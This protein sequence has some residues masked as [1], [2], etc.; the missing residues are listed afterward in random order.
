MSRGTE[1]GFCCFEP[2]PLAFKQKWT[3]LASSTTSKHATNTASLVEFCERWKDADDE[4]AERTTTVE[5]CWMNTTAQLQLIQTLH[6]VMN[7][8]IRRIFEDSMAV[9]A[10]KLDLAVVQ[11][12]KLQDPASGW[13]P[14]F[15]HFYR[16]AKSG[17]YAQQ[18][19]TLDAMIRDLE[20]W[21]GRCKAALD[22]NML[23]PNPVIDDKLKTMRE[24]RHLHENRAKAA[25]MPSSSSSKPDRWFIIDTLPCRAP[26]NIRALDTDVR[27]LAR[28]LKRADPFAFGLLNCKGVVRVFGQPQ[29]QLDLTGFDL[30]FNVPEGADA[31]RMT[32]LR[33]LLLGVGRD[34]EGEVGVGAPPSLTRRVRLAR[35]LATSDWEHNTYRHPER[36]GEFPAE[37]YRMQHESTVLGIK[38]PWVLFKDHLVELARKV[39]PRR[40]G[41]STFGDQGEVS[42]A[43]GI[44]VGVRVLYV[45][46]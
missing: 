40:M 2:K 45:R 19:S 8:E 23:D 28:K 41:D 33:A 15:L 37:E 31:T 10:R 27:D 43:N 44:L 11:V 3:P 21:Q 36:M 13:R 34:R 32:S 38:S 20:E 7:N 22:L 6:P 14:G 46:L 26:S 42:D 25:C 9:L 35:E 29:K 17:K 4:L 39:L 5:L 18:Q 16:K 24:T 1:L 30:V 12:Q